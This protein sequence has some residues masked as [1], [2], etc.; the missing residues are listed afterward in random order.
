M[1]YQKSA[2]F[3]IFLLILAAA[4]ILR[5]WRLDVLTTVSGDQGF[6]FLA[7]RTMVIE[8]NITLL[9]PK[10]GPYNE[11]GNLYLGPFYYYLLTPAL[12]LWG[13]DPIGAAVLTVVLALFTIV[14]IYMIG[15]EYFSSEAGLV[16]SAI[17]ALNPLLI[18]QSRAPSNP[19]LI[20]FF[21][22]LFIYASLKLILTR[23]S[24]SVWAIV[25]G[26]A[27][28]LAFQLHYLALALA[29]VL[30]LVLLFSR[31]VKKLLA[32]A[33]AFVLAISPQIIFELRHDF[34]VTKLFIRQLNEGDNIFSLGLLFNH[35][36]QSFKI[37][38]DI[39]IPSLQL[40]LVG[41]SILLSFFYLKKGKIN[42]NQQTFFLA[43]LVVLGLFAASLYAGSISV[44]YFVAIYVPLVILTGVLLRAVYKKSLAG[45][46]FS[47]VILVVILGSYL[48]SLNLNSQSGYT[49][50]EGWNLVGI[51]KASAIIAKEVKS[52]EKF[53]I[54]QTI[55]GDTR[56]MPLRYMTQVYGKKP[57]GVEYYPG[58]ES[59]YLLSRDSEEDIY[60]YNVWEISSFRAFKIEKH[61]D[62]QNGISL[63]LLRHPD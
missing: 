55:D 24:S 36:G 33:G 57:L 43:G 56:A 22:A 38:G 49:M 44:H 59:I 12:L 16:A 5:F 2:Y 37:L 31:Q 39:F 61:W 58:S 52:D 19:H 25:S 35:L 11:I 40:I 26:L 54:A 3:K 14:L 63:Y 30:V 23:S 60:R 17:Y 7:V 53:N 50:P 29:P 18:N 42:I 9:G 34:F 45:R 20:P 15:R 21:S 51:R 6:D 47:L 28:G 48:L 8:K 10:I 46:L 41:V 32:F 27:L 62:I 4:S 1:I 13:F